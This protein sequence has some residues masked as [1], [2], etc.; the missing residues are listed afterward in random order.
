MPNSDQI[1]ERIETFKLIAEDQISSGILPED[2]V[3]LR[4]PRI[5]W[6]VTG[7]FLLNRAY[8]KLK[9]NDGHFTQ[10]EKIAALTCMSISTFAPFRP[11]DRSNIK[12]IGAA[13]ANE[14]YALACASTILGANLKF[15]FAS[16]SNMMF[17]IMDIISESV[18]ATLEPY[19]VDLDL[20]IK[21]KV[22]DYDLSISAEDT[23]A[24]NSLITIFELLPRRR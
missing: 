3:V 9:I 11:I 22:S 19:I 12:S 4:A 20:N 16:S 18:S 13:K 5:E 21:K 7:Y 24:I 23:L 8:K 1:P 17:R 6:V 14:V 2:E 10:D 15:N